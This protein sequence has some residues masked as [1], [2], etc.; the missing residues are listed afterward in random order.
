[1]A[2]NVA[3]NQPSDSELRQVMVEVTTR[4]TTPEWSAHVAEIRVGRPRSLPIG[5]AKGFDERQQCCHV[6]F[7]VV[8]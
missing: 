2:W 1:M 3:R 7:P 4:Q 6:S 5:R 8:R